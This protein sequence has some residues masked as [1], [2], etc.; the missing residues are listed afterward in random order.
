MLTPRTL[1][2]AACLIFYAE[3]AALR[4]AEAGEPLAAAACAQLAGSSIRWLVPSRP[5][6][7][8][9]AYSRLL[10][11]FLE[12]QLQAT[13]RLENRPEAAGRMAARL[14]SDAKPDGHTL[15]MLNGIGL[16]TARLLE[17]GTTPDPLND[18]T[19]LG[20][21][22]HNHM[23][24]LVARNSGISSPQS[25]LE[26][27][28]RRPLVA[29]SADVGGSTFLVQP[30]VG[31][32]L[33]IPIELVAGYS[34]TPARV[35]ALLR[36]EVDIIL[37]NHDSV[38]AQLQ[39]GDLLA[40]LELNDAGVAGP[41]LPSLAGA[42]GYAAQR[43]GAAGHNRQ[44]AAGHADALARVAQAGRLLAA[45]GGL[46]GELQQCLDL[47]LIQAMQMPEF[48]AAAQRAKLTV[49]VASAGEAEDETREAWQAL[50]SLQDLLLNK[51]G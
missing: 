13:L 50:L 11:P 49:A 8:F 3:P 46:P 28:A 43:A 37:A 12:Q 45:P 25:L 22:S 44:I 38:S 33:D 32:L 19:L 36:G 30:V 24:L 31:K 35:L 27:A 15:G 9:D 26:L 1:L 20:R 47:A 7:G 4:A 48:Q 23:L 42:D 34:G 16:L 21:I 29:A 18:F 2:L 40:I 10:Q 17:P 41:K 39:G 5:G 6:G 14:L 51:D